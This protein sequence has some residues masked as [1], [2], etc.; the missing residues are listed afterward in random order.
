ML[1]YCWLRDNREGVISLAKKERT[2][3]RLDTLKRLQNGYLLKDSGE[4][5]YPSQAPGGNAIIKE[6]LQRGRIPLK[7]PKW[8]PSKGL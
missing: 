2:P 4:A 8:I 5:G 6:G 3:V 7:T 1:L